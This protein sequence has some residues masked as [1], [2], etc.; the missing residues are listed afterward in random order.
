MRILCNHSLF[1][2]SVVFC[3]HSLR[4][5]IVT[6]L[7]FAYVEGFKGF[8]QKFS[9][10]VVKRSFTLIPGKNG[11][12]WYHFLLAPFYSMGL[13]HATKKRMIVSWSVTTG[14]AV[15]VAAVKKLPYP[16]RNIVD[17]GVVAGLSWGSI[18][19]ILLYLKSWITGT[20][21]AMDASLP[22]TK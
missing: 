21:P 6:C 22:E 14:V 11:T 4:A 2:H 8:Q 12:K 9:P 20:P 3:T 17:A 16:Y 18:S 15:I 19:I 13:M 1:L 5:Y 10:L 7:W